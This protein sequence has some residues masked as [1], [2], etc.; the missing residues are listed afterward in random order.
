VKEK[1]MKTKITEQAVGD[2][3][4]AAFV[5][6]GADVTVAEIAARIGCSGST[7]RGTMKNG[8]APA[9]TQAEEVMR[10]RMSKNYRWQEDGAFRV[11]VYGPT[12][13]T[14]RALLLAAR[15]VVA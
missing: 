12:R 13:E 3:I 9:G 1:A 4:V 10:P 7:V 15:G 5:E 8:F 2:A 11:T 6:T 14:L